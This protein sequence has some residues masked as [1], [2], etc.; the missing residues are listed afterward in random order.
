MKNL[1]EPVDPF[2]IRLEPTSQKN[3]AYLK[4]TWAEREYLVDVSAP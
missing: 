3:L 2:T 1:D 4:I